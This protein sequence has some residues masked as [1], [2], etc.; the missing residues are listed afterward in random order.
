MS[1]RSCPAIATDVVTTTARLAAR[2]L[3][4]WG[5][6]AAHHA[7]ILGRG[8]LAPDSLDR[9]QR[10]EAMESEVTAAVPRLAMLLEISVR[11]HALVPDHDERHAWLRRR[12]PSLGDRS[13][14]E[15]LYAD[16]DGLERIS[17]LIQ[18]PAAQ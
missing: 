11:L 8:D 5:I 14:V 18:G 13:P 3:V 16:P 15:V 9:L 17:R 6:P 4:E 1:L 2:R 10:G 7:A 12:T